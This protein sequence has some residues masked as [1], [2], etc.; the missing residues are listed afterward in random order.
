LRRL[1]FPKDSKFLLYVSN[2]SYS[3]DEPEIIEEM[4]KWADEGRFQCDVRLVI[5]PYSG[6]RGGDRELDRKKF[7]R[8]SVHPRVHFYKREF[9]GDL[10]KSIYFVNIMRHADVVIAV[11]TTMALEA[12]VLDRP[13]VAP[14]FDGRVNRPLSHS[15]RRFE[16]F[17]HF[18][19]VLEIGAMKTARSFDELFRHLEAYLQNPK[20]DSSEREIMRERL[21]Y[22][23][24]GLASK[25]ICERLLHEVKI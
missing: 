18:Q 5:R 22:K 14:C 4:L 1:D 19:D 10:E 21:C 12:A 3:P 24:D 2:S 8:F 9:W 17:E 6:G 11:Y 7:E 16:E 25:R 20:L 15:I 13:L 23:L